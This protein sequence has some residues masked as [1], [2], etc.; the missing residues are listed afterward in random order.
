MVPVQIVPSQLKGEYFLLVL[1]PQFSCLIWAGCPQT[2]GQNNNSQIESFISCE[3]GRIQ[4]MLARLK[5]SI[6]PSM[7]STLDQP[8]SQATN[9]D[10]L[11]NS[12]SLS[13]CPPASNP[14][15]LEQLAAKQVQQVDATRSS[16]NN[17]RITELTEENKKLS[18]TLRHQYDWF[19]RIC[20]Q[21]RDPLSNMIIGVTSLLKYPN[22]KPQQRQEYLENIKAEC[23][24][25]KFKNEGASELVQLVNSELQADRKPL[26]LD[27]I[28]P[29]LVSTYQGLTKEK[30]INLGYTFSTKLPPIFCSPNS[31]KQ[32]V[33]KLLENSIKFTP[34]GGNISVTASVQG[35][36]V[37]LEFRDTGIGISRNE[38][39]KIF[40]LFYRV[41][42][43]SNENSNAAGVGLTI[44]KLLLSFCNGDIRV[45]S[46]LGEGS[47]FYVRFPIAPSTPQNSR[48]N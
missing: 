45:E 4:E 32:I 17:Q 37:Q 40:D 20:E 16:A 43:A 6:T 23:D 24:R 14:L 21:Q 18:N 28:V 3:K 29:G 27:E 38:T 2:R 36:Y 12:D 11:T 33:I 48:P 25:L 30:G 34:A 10:L 19:I 7:K 1:S 8:E 41:Q 39:S 13:F 35:G 5:H 47:T 22:I 26:R 46:I 9:S 44:V 42:P 31:L 15:L